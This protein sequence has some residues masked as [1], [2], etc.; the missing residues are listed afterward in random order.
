MDKKKSTI[1][2][3]D[4]NSNNL[5]VLAGVLKSNEYDF[6]LAKSGQSALNILEKTKPDL[7]LLDIQMPE[8]DGF[9][10]C[11]RIK[12][13][14]ENV[15]IPIIFLTANT[16]SVSI[17]K[18][19]DSGGVD[20]VT[21]PFNTDELLARIQTHIK[22]KNQTEELELQNATKD[23]FFSIMSHDLKNPLANIIGFSE[24]I[25]EEYK[26]LEPENINAFAGYIHESAVF[27]LEI[28]D[29]LLA[30]SRI[31]RSSLKSVKVDFNLSDLLKN[32]VE[33][34]MPQ[35]LAKNISFKSN[36]DK[37]I[38]IHADEKMI[39]TVI[40]NLISNAIKFTPNGGSIIISSKEKMV[41]NKKVVETTIQDSGIGISQ[42][43][44]PKLFSIG[45]NYSSKGTNNEG[46]TGLGL[47]LCKEFV[48]Q[49]NGE[50]RVE[51]QPNIGSSFI[52]TLENLN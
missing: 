37:D 42:E 9:E 16:D 45:Q 23:M 47:I 11:K 44:L 12:E 8:I 19:F 1:L 15:K 26:D 14:I 34:H 43:N 49:N 41:N 29:N 36:F 48:N 13:D 2:I 51:S 28:L 31:Q 7:I 20:Y 17:E 27:T 33:R 24:V 6:R 4:D 39:S 38:F 40:R 3:V 21:K 30:W 22:L 10:T 50:I 18:A 46:G 35:A 5:K 52:F 32:N 25:K